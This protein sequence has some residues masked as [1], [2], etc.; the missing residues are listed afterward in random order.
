MLNDIVPR[1]SSRS[2]RLIY[3]EHVSFCHPLSKGV[4]AG[5]INRFITIRITGSDKPIINAELVKNADR[6]YIFMHCLPAHRDLEVTADV[7]DGKHAV[8]FDQAENR[9]HAQKAVMIA[10][11]RRA[12]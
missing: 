2:V 3:Y 12:K 1:L 5:D 7:I 6:N 11:I 10:L 8:I 9:L 4:N